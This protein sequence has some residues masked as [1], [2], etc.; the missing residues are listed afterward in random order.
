C[1]TLLQHARDSEKYPF[2]VA[3]LESVGWSVGDKRAERI[4]KRHEETGAILVN[5]ANEP[6]I[7]ADFDRVLKDLYSSSARS[8]FPWLT[9]GLNTKGMK[10]GWNVPIQYV[11]DRDDLSID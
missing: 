8:I 9:T 5:D 10:G 7:D 1:E 11:F 3:L 2:Y 4:F 6:I